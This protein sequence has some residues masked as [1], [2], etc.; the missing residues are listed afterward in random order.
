MRHRARSLA[1]P[2]PRTIIPGPPRA[3]RFVLCKFSKNK[4]VRRNIAKTTKTQRLKQSCVP[5]R[6]LCFLCVLGPF[7]KSWCVSLRSGPFL[8]VLAWFSCL[9]G[10][11]A[12]AA[13]VQ[14][15]PRSPRSSPESPG[16]YS[17]ESPEF[18]GVGAPQPP[19]SPEFPGVPRN[20]P[21]AH[22]G[23]SGPMT[24]KTRNTHKTNRISPNRPE[25]SKDYRNRQE[26]GRT[27]LKT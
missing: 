4:R 2:E 24:R 23:Q 19:E 12:A 8:S 13:T 15:V 9:G 11:L 16:V 22:P 27:A 14:V 26:L 3:S 1:R 17:P 7:L 5:M 25:T 18:P 10:R 21:E 20:H 6:L